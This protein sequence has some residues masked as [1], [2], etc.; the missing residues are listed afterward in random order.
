MTTPAAEDL[1]LAQ[2]LYYME[3]RPIA[4]YNPHDKPF[5]EL[6][7]IYGFNNGG[8]PGWYSG[9]LLSEDGKFLG[10]HTC[11]KEG[12]MP[13]DLGILEGCRPDRH[14]DNFKPHYPDGYRM[15][16]VPHEEVPNHEGLNKA[17]ELH[18]QREATDE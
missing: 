3:G 16:F 6:P 10:S 17:I 8:S 12:Y 1:Y 9:V 5:E 14:K 4:Y 15:Q 18:Q 11:S 13:Y 7:I 2:H